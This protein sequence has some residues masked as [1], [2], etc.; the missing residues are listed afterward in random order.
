MAI[1]LDVI[2]M[3]G[4]IDAFDLG[5]PN[6]AGLGDLLSY[7]LI[8]PCYA[9][10]FLNYFKQERKWI[11]V[12]IFTLLS[13]L[14]EWLLVQVGFME[15]KGWNTWWSL[16]VYIV[17]FGFWLPWHLKIIRSASKT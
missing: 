13:I 14:S 12:V 9:V 4:L 16:P 8:A 10:I 5:D 3:S 1:L 2:V 6:T 17:I 15:L 11:Y 7:S